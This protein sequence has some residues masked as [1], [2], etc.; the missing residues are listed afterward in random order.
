M[1]SWIRLDYCKPPDCREVLFYVISVDE[2]F[3]FNHDY[4]VSGFYSE[5]TDDF[6]LEIPELIL[7]DNKPFQTEFLKITH[8][9]PLPEKPLKLNLITEKELQQIVYDS[10][11]K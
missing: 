3:N 7:D 5:E 10:R 1:N 11:D 4:L 9:Q 8:W 6:Y 2:E